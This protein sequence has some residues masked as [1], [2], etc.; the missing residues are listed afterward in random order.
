[1]VGGGGS[2][3]G[4][5]GAAAQG[6]HGCQSVRHSVTVQRANTEKHH[7]WPLGAPGSGPWARVHWVPSI[8]PETF[9]MPMHP[10]HPQACLLSSR[11]GRKGSAGQGGPH[12]QQGYFQQQLPISGY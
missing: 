1:M 4:G 12:T 8:C 10:G 6:G 11:R 3:A 9:E 5:A 2:G 7:T